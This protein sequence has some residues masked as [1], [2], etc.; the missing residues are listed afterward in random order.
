MSHQDGDRIGLPVPEASTRLGV[1]PDA[2]RARLHRGTL[3]GEKAAGQWVVYLP[4]ETALPR[5]RLQR[6]ADSPPTG[7]QLDAAVGRQERDR[8]G[9][10]TPSGVDLSPLAELIERQGDEIR[11]LAEASLVWQTRALQAEAKLLALGAG[12]DSAMAESFAPGDGAADAGD[13][14]RA[15]GADDSASTADALAARPAP[16]SEAEH[17]WAPH[18]HGHG[19]AGERGSCLRNKDCRGKMHCVDGR[20]C[21][22][23]Q[24]PPWAQWWR[25]LTGR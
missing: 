22:P 1:T 11:R 23:P 21:R 20:C 4:T 13:G 12:D 8:A 19:T 7:P 24:P 15:R 16:R 10:V 9:P 2:I 5:T 3:D 14:V 18:D 17:R 25:R 6:D